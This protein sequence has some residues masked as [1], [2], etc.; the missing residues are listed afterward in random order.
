[1]VRWLSPLA[2]LRKAFDAEMLTSLR[3]QYFLNIGIGILGAAYLLALG[4]IL[5]A[6]AFGTYTLCAA[7]PAVAAALLDSRL[8]EFVLYIKENWERSEFPSIVAA[9][10]WFDLASKLLLVAVA[11]GAY[12]L[13]SAL[14]YDGIILLYVALS[15]A[16]TFA[17]KCL[18]GPSLGVLRATGNLEF[19]SIIQVMDWFFRLAALSALYF[20]GYASIA[21][22]AGRRVIRGSSTSPCSAS[23]ARRRPANTSVR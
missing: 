6:A 2:T 19:F 5:G 15:A 3:W 8:Q 10:Y 16:L 1:M 11:L 21:T 14:R 22:S 23:T 7:I 9:L 12:A 4:R 13:L 17:S 20:T 18:S